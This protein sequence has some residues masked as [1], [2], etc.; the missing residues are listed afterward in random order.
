MERSEEEIKKF[1]DF[2]KKWEGGLSSDRHDSASSFTNPI[3]WMG[4]L[5]W[6]TNK[7]ITWAAWVS[8][9]GDSKESAIEFYKMPD[10]KWFQ[11]FKEGYWDKVRADDI[12]SF[13]VAVYVTGMAWG[14]GPK[15]AIKLLQKAIN[16]ISDKKV[17]EDGVIGPNTLRA[18]NACDESELFDE[19]LKVREDFFRKIASRGSENARFLNGW[20]RRLEDYRKTFSPQ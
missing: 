11:V 18:T 8:K 6:H 7:G 15:P 20:L 14:S 4:E 19:L 2:T 1:V 5:G 12:D 16:N 3:P 10:D 13:A 9:F 17:S